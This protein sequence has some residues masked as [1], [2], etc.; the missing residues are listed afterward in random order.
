MWAERPLRLPPWSLAAC[1]GGFRNDNGTIDD[2]L[3]S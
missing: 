2:T 3:N 1:D